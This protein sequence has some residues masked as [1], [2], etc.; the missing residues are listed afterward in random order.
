MLR[1]QRC[2]AHVRAQVSAALGPDKERTDGV[3]WSAA[4]ADPKTYAEVA[5]PS[6]VS[7]TD[8]VFATLARTIRQTFPNAIVAP[9]VVTAATDARHYESIS[10]HVYRFLPLR[11][12]ARD[13]ERLHGVDE[14]I[15]RRDYVSAVHFYARFL[16]NIDEP[17]K[18]PGS[19][20]LIMPIETKI[21]DRDHE[22]HLVVDEKPRPAFRA[23]AKEAIRTF[24]IG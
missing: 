9:D 17:R 18:S 16:M 4:F 14:R 6:A 15:A 5:E 13:L 10:S 8:A 2:V 1:V 23:G 7:P 3:S 20:S 19:I 11:L 22:V 21:R 24:G 12:N